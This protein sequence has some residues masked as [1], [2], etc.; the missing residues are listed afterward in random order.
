MKTAD[1]IFAWALVA[2]GCVHGA[3]AFLVF[4]TLSLE[5][6]WF[7][8][9]SLAMIFTAML[10]LLR[11][12]RETDR[13]LTGACCIANLLSALLF[14]AVVPWVVR[15]DLKDHPQVFVVGFVVFVELVFSLRQWSK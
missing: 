2:L 13:G 14:D 9:G 1:R 12:G 11:V 4:K 6:V 5:T 7:I 15:H 3:A 8:C 10:N